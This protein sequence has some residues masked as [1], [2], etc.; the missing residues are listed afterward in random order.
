MPE[1]GSYD[2]HRSPYLYCKQAHG[3]RDQWLVSSPQ[4]GRSSVAAAALAAAPGECSRCFCLPDT[5]RIGC[6][7]T[8]CIP[9]PQLPVVRRNA[10]ALT[11]SAHADTRAAMSGM[12]VN[13]EACVRANNGRAF[14]RGSSHCVCHQDGSVGC[15]AEQ[16]RIRSV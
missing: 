1:L 9:S 3:G 4:H 8:S 6:M 5:Q 12:Y 11:A 10:R 15:A 16:T 14:T 7:R 2:M 13:H